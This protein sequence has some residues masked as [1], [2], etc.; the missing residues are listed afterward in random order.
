[1]EPTWTT[2]AAVDYGD[3]FDSGKDTTKYMVL[4]QVGKEGDDII[5]VEVA[6]VTHMR[7]KFDTP[8]IAPTPFLIKAADVKVRWVGKKEDF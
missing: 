6:R 4:G 1:M 7:L 3:V 8:E 2:L 5:Y